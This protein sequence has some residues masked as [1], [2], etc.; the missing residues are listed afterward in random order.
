MSVYEHRKCLERAAPLTSTLVSSFMHVYPPPATGSHF[1]HLL[2]LVY[3]NPQGRRRANLPVS[4]RSV[5]CEEDT[6]LFDVAV[7]LL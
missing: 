5:H 7:G 3:Q 4:M 1:L 6:E 2:K